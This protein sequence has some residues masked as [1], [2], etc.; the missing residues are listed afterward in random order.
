MCRFWH[1]FFVIISLTQGGSDMKI[2][3]YSRSNIEK[4]IEGDFPEKTVVISFMILS[5]FVV[6]MNNLL[7][8]R[9]RLKCC[10]R[11]LFMILI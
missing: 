8:I 9:V 5:V 4:L 2:S 10:F 11:L 1:I 6:I 3:I 7:I